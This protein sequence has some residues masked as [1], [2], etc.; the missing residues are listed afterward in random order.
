MKNLFADGPCEQLQVIAE[1]RLGKI[2]S[3]FEVDF[4][5]NIQLDRAIACLRELSPADSAKVLK[6]WLNGRRFRSPTWCCTVGWR[7]FWSFRPTWCYTVGAWCGPGRQLTGSG[8]CLPLAPISLSKPPYLRLIVALL[9]RGS[10][11]H[12]AG[13]CTPVSYTHLTL[14]TKMIV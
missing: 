8:V 4:E 2:F 14:P 11:R 9:V 7:G 10:W 13:S 5:D 6:T 3:P 12:H 1:A